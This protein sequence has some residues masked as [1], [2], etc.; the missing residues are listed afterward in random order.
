MPDLVHLHHRL[1]HVMLLSLLLEGTLHLPLAG[2]RLAQLQALLLQ[3]Q[4]VNLHKAQQLLQQL[5]LSRS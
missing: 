5:L 1:G 3:V 2:H 4:A